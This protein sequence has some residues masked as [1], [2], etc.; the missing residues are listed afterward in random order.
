MRAINNGNLIYLENLYSLLGG[1]N[2]S[3]QQGN[4]INKP[5]YIL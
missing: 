5:V 1:K 4:R 2:V 3:V